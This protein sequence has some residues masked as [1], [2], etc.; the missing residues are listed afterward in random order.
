MT[1]LSGTPSS[2]EIPSTST[3]VV[4][5]DTMGELMLLLLPALPIWPLLAVGLVN[6]EGIIRWKLPHTLFRY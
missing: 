5:G 4:V 6:V 1:K 2:G 3:Q